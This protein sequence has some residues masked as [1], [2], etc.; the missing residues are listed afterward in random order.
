MIFCLMA[1][2]LQKEG[3]YAQVMRE[4]TLA[5]GAGGA[6]QANVG[7]T[8]TKAEKKKNLSKLAAAYG[9]ISDKEYLLRINSIL[10]DE[11]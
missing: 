8:N 7:R 9:T 10:K 5:V 2:L 4:N 3:W 1:Y 6:G 11:L